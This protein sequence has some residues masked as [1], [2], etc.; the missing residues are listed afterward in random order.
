MSSFGFLKLVKSVSY[1]Y[2]NIAKLSLFVIK[3]HIFKISQL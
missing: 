3:L 2:R 1:Q